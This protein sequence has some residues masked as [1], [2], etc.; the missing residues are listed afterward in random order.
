LLEGEKELD[1]LSLRNRP[2][3]VSCKRRED[4]GTDRLLNGLPDGRR[5]FI[6]AQASRALGHRLRLLS[7][8]LLYPNNVGETISSRPFALLK[9][10]RRFLLMAY[11]RL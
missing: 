1:L 2:A 9:S 5:S 11:Q 8:S 4:V 3:C 6:V 10:C 7:S